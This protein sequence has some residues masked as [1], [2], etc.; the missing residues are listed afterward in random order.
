M[1]RIWRRAQTAESIRPD[2]HRHH[3]SQHRLRDDGES[4][5]SLQRGTD[6][7]SK[8]PRPA[9]AKAIEVVKRANRR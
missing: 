3:R 1:W 9:I 4:L 7:E 5:W 6:L 8:R 2:R